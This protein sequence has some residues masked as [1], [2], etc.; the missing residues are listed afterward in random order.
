M[1]ILKL[2]GLSNHNVKAPFS[3]KKFELAMP[4][5]VVLEKL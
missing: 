1:N 5:F 3:V 2:V 4:A